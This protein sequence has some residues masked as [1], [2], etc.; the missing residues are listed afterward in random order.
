MNIIEIL[1]NF[2]TLSAMD[3]DVFLYS[4]QPIKSWVCTFLEKA[5]IDFFLIP[6]YKRVWK[7]FIEQRTEN[8]GLNIK[9]RGKIKEIKN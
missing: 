2:V 1:S 9:N 4:Y 5:I 6:L 3:F 8:K 7:G